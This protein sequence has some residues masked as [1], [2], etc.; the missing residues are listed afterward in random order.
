MAQLMGIDIGTGSAKVLIID[1][2]GN[3][4]ANA[5]CEYPISSRHPDWAE[6]DPEWWWN[7]VKNA[8]R[9]IPKDILTNVSAVGLT[10]QMHGTVL[11][12]K[13]LEPLRQAIIWADKRSFSLCEKIYEKIGKEDIVKICCN[14]IMPGF[15]ATSLLWIK[16]NEPTIF[17]NACKVLL[18]KDYLRLKMSGICA[19]DV[20]D[21][22]AT[23]LFDVRKRRWSNSIISALD[24]SEE[25]L[26]Q[27]F[28]ST[29]V[30]GEVSSKA[31]KETGLRKGTLIVA[32]GGDSPVG[33]MSCG[34][35]KEGLVS[36]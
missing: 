13:N 12:G 21:A 27:L 6:Q 32:G 2:N 30:T 28:N 16:E 15:M 22:S 7:A 1:E 17:K 11:L 8:L 19:T 18:P 33:A 36:P 35:I 4:I 23:L 9:R 24:F 20:S 34:A 14:P 26:P 5:S 29:D 25:L 10:G 31:S 3:V